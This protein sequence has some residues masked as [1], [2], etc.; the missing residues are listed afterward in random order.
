MK[1]SAMPVAPDRGAHRL[2]GSHAGRAAAA[3][4]AVA[5]VALTDHAARP[6]ITVKGISW[7]G[8]GT[9][10]FDETVA[11]FT[12]VLGLE[13][14]LIQ[15]PVAMLHAGPGAVVEIFGPGSS[16][17]RPL[18]SPPS[19]AFEV[20]DVSAARDALVAAGVELIGEIGTWNGFEW[21]YFR[22]PEDY[23]FSV[24]TTPEAGWERS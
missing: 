18:N 15:D 16:R 24:K 6:E 21:L 4:R 3:A 2:T 22:G 11:F 8:I 1:S 20:E 7:V 9:G 10:S 19:V 23:I 12:K 17:G 13:V 5:E 14:A